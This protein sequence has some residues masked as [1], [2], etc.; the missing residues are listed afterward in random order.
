MHKSIILQRN[1]SNWQVDHPLSDKPE[2]SR[3]LLVL[4]QNF[5]KS[6][7]CLLEDK[8]NLGIIVGNSEMEA[9]ERD[10]FQYQPP[11]LL[12]RLQTLDETEVVDFFIDAFNAFRVR[13]ECF[14]YLHTFARL[15]LKYCSK[16]AFPKLLS[17]FCFVKVL[18]LEHLSKFV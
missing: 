17:D 13:S 2:R 3:I 4:L 10:D 6:I 12:D 9:M 14:D 18:Q 5:W 11:L 8:E 15:V 1:E 16:A 7:I